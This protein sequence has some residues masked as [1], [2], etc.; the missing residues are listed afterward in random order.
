MEIEWIRIVKMSAFYWVRRVAVETLTQIS[1]T[2]LRL[3]KGDVSL[4]EKATSS[5]E[6]R[7]STSSQSTESAPPRLPLVKPCSPGSNSLNEP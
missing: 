6:E 3:S 1:N 7:V 2:L 4:Y 5:F